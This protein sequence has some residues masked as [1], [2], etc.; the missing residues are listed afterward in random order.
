[1]EELERKVIQQEETKHLVN[2]EREPIAKKEEDDDIP[3]I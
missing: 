1:M 3:S 2:V